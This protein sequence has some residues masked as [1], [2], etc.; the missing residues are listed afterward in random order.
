MKDTDLVFS[1]KDVNGR[2]EAVNAKIERINEAVEY[3]SK[4]QI[5]AMVEQ[6]KRAKETGGQD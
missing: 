5:E 6:L 3:V 1:G 2:L 4:A